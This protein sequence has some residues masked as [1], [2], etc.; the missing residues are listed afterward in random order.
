ML[1]I[2]FSC[3][4]HISQYVF[5][6]KLQELLA[7][8]LVCFTATLFL[9]KQNNIDTWYG[10]DLINKKCLKNVLFIYCWF[11]VCTITRILASGTHSFWGTRGY[12]HVG[13]WKSTGWPWLVVSGTIE[14]RRY[15]IIE[16]H[17][18]WF[19]WMARSGPW[20]LYYC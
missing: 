5:Q 11:C 6:Q 7:A 16:N 1:L 14:I 20:S 10:K 12:H 9:H 13:P 15:Q 3:V 8:S 19:V 4:S 18:V 17:L 2:M